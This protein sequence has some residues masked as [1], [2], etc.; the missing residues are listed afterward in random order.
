MSDYRVTVTL[1]EPSGI[2]VEDL[3]DTIRKW[4]HD[5]EPEVHIEGRIID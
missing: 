1:T 2:E 5:N 4:R 3:L